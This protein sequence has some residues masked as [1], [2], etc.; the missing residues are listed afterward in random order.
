MKFE[1]DQ[2]EAFELLQTTFAKQF[3]II[4][5]R[6][7][8]RLT[9]IK[10]KSKRIFPNLDLSNII[11]SFEDCFINEN[12]EGLVYARCANLENKII[13]INCYPIANMLFK[14]F[15]ISEVLNFYRMH[16][17]LI[18]EVAHIIDYMLNRR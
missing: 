7:N 11:L 13:E 12:E 2:F 4:K 5:L 9:E 15:S 10:I 6:L 1:L 8:R 16:K 3:E 14:Q 18:H 17:V